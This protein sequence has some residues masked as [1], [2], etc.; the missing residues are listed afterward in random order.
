MEHNPP[1]LHPL[2]FQFMS[3]S[4]VSPFLRTTTLRNR[5]PL[6]I[7]YIFWRKKLRPNEIKI[8]QLNSFTN[9]QYKPIVHQKSKYKPLFQRAPRLS[10]EEKHINKVNKVE[11]C[12]TEFRVALS[13]H[14]LSNLMFVRP[15]ILT[16]GSALPTVFSMHPKVLGKY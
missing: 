1:A 3:C 2:M 13:S 16:V 14:I 15:C 8:G 12:R 6:I 11:A 5:W 7:T 4:H 9:L 10:A